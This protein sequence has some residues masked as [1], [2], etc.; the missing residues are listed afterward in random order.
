MDILVTTLYYC[1]AYGGAS[2]LVLGTFIIVLWLLVKLYDYLE[3]R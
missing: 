1:L 2:L 3:A